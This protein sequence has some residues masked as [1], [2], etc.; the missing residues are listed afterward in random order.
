MRARFTNPVKCA[1]TVAQFRL[2]IVAAL[3]IPQW[4]PAQSRELRR[5]PLDSPEGRLMGFY[6][7]TLAANPLGRPFDNDAAPWSAELSLELGYVPRLNREQRTAGFDKPEASNL[8]PVLPRPRLSVL[9]PGANTFD[10]SWVPPVR[11]V[12]AKANLF[13]AA[14]RH[15]F[16]LGANSAAALVPRFSILHG[17]VEGAITC[18][19]DLAEGSQSDVFY[20]A[21]VCNAHPS[22]DY[23]DPTHYSFDVTLENGPRILGGSSFFTAGARREFTRF[24]IGVI[25]PGDLRDPDHPVPGV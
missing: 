21:F 18:S 5:Y 6:S 9:L 12:D 1:L 8:S 11:V 17:R 24:D 7:S 16:S 13:S 23:F 19:R 20:Y 10:V 14:L 4:L 25:V 15:S 3:A 2:L 22:R